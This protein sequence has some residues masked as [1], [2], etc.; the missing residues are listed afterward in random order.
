MFSMP[1]P[2]PG[3]P[4]DYSS[5]T[6]HHSDTATISYPTHLS[7]TTPSSSRINGDWGFKRPFPLRTTTRSTIPLIRIKQVDSPEHITDFQSS[8]DH[9]ITLE[10]FQELNLPI[11]VPTGNSSD[12]TYFDQPGKSVFEEDGD[13]TA[14]PDG[15]EEELENKR[16]RFRGPW[17]AGMTDGQFDK[18]IEKV[19]RGKRTEFRAFLKQ[20]LAAEMTA[21]QELAAM[22]NQ[23]AK[24]D[25]I[26]GSDITEKQLLEYLKQLRD[27]RFRLFRL[28]G[29]FLDLAPL[30]AEL[31]TQHLFSETKR[32]PTDRTG[33]DLD[34]GSPYSMNGPPIT[35]PSA[36][37]SYL[38]T[39]NFGENH[40]L[41]GPQKQHAA[42][43]SRILAPRN[44]ESGLYSPAIGVA[45]FVVDNK[46]GDT[47][48]NQMRAAD[49]KV[50]SELYRFN[51]QTEGGA[52]EYTVP[53]TA[54]V[55]SNGRVVISIDQP[56][57]QSKLVQQELEGEHDLFEEAIQAAHRPEIPRNPRGS[58]RHS[59]GTVRPMGTSAGYGLGGKFG[60]DT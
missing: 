5:A 31:Q 38:R 19:V 54:T 15:K 34:R 27:D 25:P 14:I 10:K 35:H 47:T 18:Y 21:D 13:V 4:N 1:A 6:K 45:G 3:P 57:A 9:S 29:R 43:K 22:D 20:K 58:G 50:N 53:K 51:P 59:R 26:S 23:T 33:R 60:R 11:S 2:I 44:P 56:N 40:P 55:T 49:P 17:L 39:R 48:F 30:S 8:S 37:L 41:Y 46:Y 32:K 36:G 12:L 28:V 16:W 24:P 7:V 42:V 52:K